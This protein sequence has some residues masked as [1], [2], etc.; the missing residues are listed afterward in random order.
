MSM[1]SYEPG[2]TV[3]PTGAVEP[4]SPAPAQAAA[5]RSFRKPAALAVGAVTT[6]LTVFLFA[7]GTLPTPGVLPFGYNDNVQAGQIPAPAT[8][9]L[10]DYTLVASGTPVDDLAPKAGMPEVDHPDASGDKSS[11][12]EK[13][14][15][16]NDHGP[17]G[18]D[19]DSNGDQD[20]GNTDGDDGP[21]GPGEPGDS[22]PDDPSG[23]GE[24]IDDTTNN[25][26]DTVGQVTGTVDDLATA[27]DDVVET[28]TG[29]DP[30]LDVVVDDTTDLVDDVVGGVL[31]GVGGALNPGG[32]NGG[33]GNGGGSGG[34][35][36]LVDDA[37]GGILGAPAKHMP[38][39]DLDGA[40]DTDQVTPLITN[41]AAADSTYLVALLAL[42][43]YTAEPH[44]PNALIEP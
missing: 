25:L 43:G 3:M 4:P 24:V 22:G 40:T 44:S 13:D 17:V 10:P 14:D 18:D 9:L 6:S 32:G 5:P 15:K 19:S 23:P 31:G 41:M 8:E 39:P 29:T 12:G 26:N 1:H 28:V 11:Q 16:G 7:S 21:D 33:G 27:V 35:G 20:G 34:L 42:L 38:L 36:A 2:A 37:V 30:G